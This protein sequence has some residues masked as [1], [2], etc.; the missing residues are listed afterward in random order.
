MSAP[1][2]LSLATLHAAAPGVLDVVF[3]P[4]GDF[5]E[6]LCWLPS[7]VVTLD[8]C[9]PQHERPLFYEPF[10][11]LMFRDG[12]WELVLWSV[13][14][15]DLRVPSVFARMERLCSFV[16]DVEA[17]MEP[18]ALAALTLALAPQIAALR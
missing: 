7:A 13:L 6:A 12:A 2:L 1:Y 17:G 14:A 10:G 3:G 18:A 5:E 15:L 16:Q 9:E 11:L 8:G 4:D